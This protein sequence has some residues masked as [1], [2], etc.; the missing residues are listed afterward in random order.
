[1]GHQNNSLSAARRH[2]TA[3]DAANSRVVSP[4]PSSTAAAP[5]GCCRWPAPALAARAGFTVGA[6]PP[7]PASEQGCTG[8]AAGPAAAAAGG[9]GGAFGQC[10]GTLAAGQCWLNSGD[11]QQGFHL[12]PHVQHHL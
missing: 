4:K 11:H 12:G 7:R 6:G 5:R 1:M 9:G 8:A 10:Q 3:I 2:R